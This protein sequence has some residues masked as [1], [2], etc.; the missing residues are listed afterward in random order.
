MEQYF[1]D[2]EIYKEQDLL[3]QVSS[4]R[5]RVVLVLIDNKTYIAQLYVLDYKV[6]IAKLT[7][8]NLTPV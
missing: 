6:K 3:G 7:S 8:I 4:L 1:D 5:K 2:D